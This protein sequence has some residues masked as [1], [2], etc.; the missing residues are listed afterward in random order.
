MKVSIVTINY[1][2]KEGLCKTIDSV[3]CQT[4]KDY[5]W[6]VIDGGSSDGS[7]AL[8]EQYGGHFSFWCSEPDK[9]IYNAMNKGIAQAHGD[10]LLFLNS[11]DCLHDNEVL[12]K[13][14]SLNSNVDII[15][16]ISVS[17][18]TGE[19]MK[20]F[21]ED[22]LRQLYYDSLNHQATF[23][24]RSLFEKHKY[25]EENKIASDWEFFVQ[26]I[27]IDGCSYEY[28][29]IIVADFDTTGISNQSQWVKTQKQERKEIL[30]K[31]FSSYVRKDIV[32]YFSICSSSEYK[33][34][35]F[36]KECPSIISI[37]VRKLNSFI[38]RLL[39][40]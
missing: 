1:N 26:T 3:V 37:L 24:K 23:I 15:A 18:E 22:I 9:G 16:G 14:N 33:K 32:N 7:K 40:N 27:L 19:P 39:Q 30:E 6:I 13:F 28:S 12:A 21:D 4:Y 38:Y 17:Q 29:S 35:M 34:M 20:V 25:N 31:Y 36:F 5:E 10:Y 11:G 2:N 8:I